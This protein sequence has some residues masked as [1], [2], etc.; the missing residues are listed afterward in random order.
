M[1][2]SE[3]MN[4]EILRKPLSEGQKG[5]QKSSVMFC[6]FEF[7]GFRCTLQNK[8]FGKKHM[9]HNLFDDIVAICHIE[10]AGGSGDDGKQKGTSG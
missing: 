10:K 1:L 4:I 7:N 9:A 6:G 5:W 3:Q 8:H 2:T